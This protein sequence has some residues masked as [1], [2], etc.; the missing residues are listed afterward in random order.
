[1]S[2]PR[3]AIIGAGISGLAAAWKLREAAIDVTVFDKSR[4]VSG[5]AASR[6]RHGARFDFGAN[7]FK[8]ENPELK[9]LVLNDLP[10]TDLGRIEREVWTFDAEGRMQP[11]DPIQNR[12]SRWTYSS[13]IST[14]GKLLAE[15]A[16]VDVGLGMRI[17]GLQQLRGSWVLQAEDK[18][19]TVD[20]GY[21]AVLLT[22]PAPQ[23]H[24]ILAASALGDVDG[25]KLEAALASAR[26][27]QQLVFAL[28]FNPPLDKRPDCFALIN[29]DRAHDIAWLSFEND[30]PGRDL[31]GSTVMMVQMSPDWSRCH[32]DEPAGKLVHEVAAIAL[33]LLDVTHRPVDWFD[34]QR[35]RFAHP[36]QPAAAS[37]LEQGEEAGLF[38]A[39]DALV[40]K[41]RVEE[42]MATGLRAADRI[43]KRLT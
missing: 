37:A 43:V 26:Y 9:Q 19:I 33:K 25:E 24:D 1:M 28:G 5:R 16:G 11:G 21:D 10:T 6:T 20:T 13:G 29:S 15:A 42:A 40:G 14:L 32:F 31:G 38:F 17:T 35:W 39:G 7:Y 41:G 8:L 27:H 36:Y 23:T 22:P 2:K 12:Q 3:L 18:A 34:S 4:G 30:K